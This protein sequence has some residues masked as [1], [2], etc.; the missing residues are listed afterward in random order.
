MPGALNLNEQL[1]IC[2]QWSENDETT[3]Q[4]ELQRL[5]HTSLVVA[6]IVID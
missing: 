3:M 6:D 5:Q 4:E 2:L 1:F